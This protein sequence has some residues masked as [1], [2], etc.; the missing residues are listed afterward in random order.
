MFLI[1]YSISIILLL[2]QEADSCE[3][4]E[5]I[6]FVITTTND[7]EFSF[8]LPSSAMMVELSNRITSRFDDEYPL[9]IQLLGEPLISSEMLN[10]QT[11]AENPRIASMWNTLAEIWNATSGFRIPL[12][13]KRLRT[14][15]EHGHNQKDTAVYLSLLRMFAGADSNAHEFE[16]HKFVQRC[17]ASKT[18]S[19]EELCARFQNQFICNDGHLIEIKL[20]QQI[21]SGI[22]YLAY[23][24]PTVTRLNLQRNSLTAIHGLDRLVGKQLQNLMI[25][26]NPLELDL[27]PLVRSASSGN[28]PLRALS[29]TASQVR[30][31]S[32]TTKCKRLGRGCG[33]DGRSMCEAAQK[34]IDSSVLDSLMIGR[35]RCVTIQRS[36]RLH[37]RGH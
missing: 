4:A 18:C 32:Q 29:V 17:A 11:I 34:W 1:L 2:L 25:K 23:L 10:H 8:A 26:M 14:Q 19:I 5:A 12:K 7:E 33:R 15:L 3:A 24:P 21:L 36:E 16:W 22:V 20:N 28:N 13:I 37:A 31:F 9:E 6:N 27:R 35:F 30:Y